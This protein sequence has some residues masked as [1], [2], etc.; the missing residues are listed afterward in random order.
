MQCGDYC[1]KVPMA[2]VL[3]KKR[4]IILLYNVLGVFSVS[5]ALWSLRHQG[6]LGEKSRRDSSNICSA[7]GRGFLALLFR[8]VF[9]WSHGYFPCGSY[10]LSFVYA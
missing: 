7:G 4:Q 8:D 3:R 5:S 6:G 1:K 2:S 9:S 10:L